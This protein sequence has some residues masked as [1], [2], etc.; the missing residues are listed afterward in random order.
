M[1]SEYTDFYTTHSLADDDPNLLKS[2]EST[3]PNCEIGGIVGLQD[4][5]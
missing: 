1:F 3:T 4:L 5:L 2:M